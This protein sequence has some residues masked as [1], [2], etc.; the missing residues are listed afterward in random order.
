[1]SKINLINNLYNRQAHQMEANGLK[2][3]AIQNKEQNNFTSILSHNLMDILGTTKQSLINLENTHQS[4]LN[5]NRVDPL[6]IAN[7]ANNARLTLDTMKSVLEQTVKA[8]KEI[9]A[10]NI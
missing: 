7:L 9:M 3:Q 2:T 8:V 10:T 1:M 5:G 4:M 6:V